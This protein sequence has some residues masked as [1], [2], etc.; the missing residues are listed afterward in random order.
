MTNPPLANPSFIA[1][2]TVSSDLFW[3]VRD[4]I[5]TIDIMD[6]TLPLNL[7]TL[8]VWRAYRLSRV[9]DSDFGLDV[10]SFVAGCCVGGAA[11]DFGFGFG[12]FRTNDDL[13]RRIHVES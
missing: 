8:L 1:I 11:S 6:T 9:D 5:L 12:T 4:G 13:M 3:G 7:S 10:F 2:Q